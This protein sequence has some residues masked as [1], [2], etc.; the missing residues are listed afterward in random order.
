[1]LVETGVSGA[2]LR[3]EAS[4]IADQVEA[5]FSEY[6]ESPGDGRD[7]LFEAM[8]HAGLGGG[9]P[10]GLAGPA[11]VGGDGRAPRARGGG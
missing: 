2:E 5:V 4:R 1:M 7:R 10:V 11:G 3:T 6:L 9:K 8:R